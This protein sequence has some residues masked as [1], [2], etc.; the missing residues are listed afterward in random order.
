MTDKTVQ[1]IVYSVVHEDGVAI[2]VCDALELFMRRH[3]KAIA[4]EDNELR[5][6]D[7][8]PHVTP[9]VTPEVVEALLMRQEREE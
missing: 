2:D 5:F 6:V 7:L 3:N 9:R 4:V 8:I 1:G